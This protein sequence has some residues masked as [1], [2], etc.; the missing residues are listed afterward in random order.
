MTHRRLVMANCAC[1][2]Q[3]IKNLSPHLRVYFY[4]N[5]LT[6]MD[7]ILFLLHLIKAKKKKTFYTR[8]VIQSV[9]GEVDKNT[10][11]NEIYL[12]SKRDIRSIFTTSILMFRSLHRTA[13]TADPRV[14]GEGYFYCYSP[15][16]PFH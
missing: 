14:H 10:K 5:N 7:K 11:K 3:H 2:D 4:S 12:R 6:K 8:G 16:N 13:E 1:V 15:F 9:S